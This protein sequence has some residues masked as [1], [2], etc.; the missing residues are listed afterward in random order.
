MTPNPRIQIFQ[1]KDVPRAAFA[2]R[3]W[4]NPS[5]PGQLGQMRWNG[6][7]FDTVCV[8]AGGA[9]GKGGQPYVVT[10]AFVTSTVPAATCEE[11]G[12]RFAN[13]IVFGRTGR[14][15]GRLGNPTVFELECALAG[16]HG[17]GDAMA[18]GSGMAA[19]AHLVLG[20]VTVGDNIVVH[21]T[22]YGCS[23]DL[24]SKILPALGIE[25]RF[26]DMRD[27]SVLREAV[28][29]KTRLVF[30][31]TPA[32]PTLELVNIADV[33]TEVNGRCPV[34]VDNTIASA[35]A[36]NPIKQ[37]ANIVVYS[38]TKSMGGHSRSIGGAIVASGPFLEHYFEIRNTIGGILS[39]EEALNFLDGLKTLP[40]RC[41]AMQAN[42]M[43]IVEMLQG[44]RA[45]QMVH[46]PSLDTAYPLGGQMNGPGHLIAFELKGGLAAGR[47]F[48]DALQVVT[49]AVS[50]GG[51][52]SL[53]CHPA[54][55][56]HAVVPQEEREAKGITDGLVRLSAGI[57]SQQL[58]IED[59][60]RGLDAVSRP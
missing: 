4:E 47:A 18:F 22:L 57:E 46:Y 51:V 8:H 1:P 12:N 48:I 25:V 41:L 29:S 33:V 39:P 35:Y 28:D 50:M 6:W 24:F 40:L 45:V 27:P 10:P 11:L 58:L 53:A 3:S 5:Q 15:Y 60:Q 19:I 32:N 2:D 23:D 9:R 20:L 44:H 56:T 16:I 43:A 26:V 55:T 7:D 36:Q 37:G 30:F 17:S 52:E 54:T 59:I 34:A 49:N 21:R 42:A 38:L 31:E 14:I 13:G